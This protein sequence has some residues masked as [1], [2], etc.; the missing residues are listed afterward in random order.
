MARSKEYAVFAP[1][2]ARVVAAVVA[3]AFM[4][5]MILLGFLSPGSGILDKVGFIGVGVGVAWLMYRLAGV[6][7]TPSPTGLVVRN[8]FITT[9]LEW[10]QIVSV[11]FGD[12]PWVLLDL[13]DGETLSVMGIQ[14]ADGEFGRREAVRLADLVEEHGAEDH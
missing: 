11:R 13:S 7:A 5:M 12:R 9:R 2:R 14:R 1:R 3:V 8:L 10:A 6:H 4:I